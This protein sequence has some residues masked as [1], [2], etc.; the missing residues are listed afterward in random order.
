MSYDQNASEDF[1]M[2]RRRGGSG[3]IEQS[4]GSVQERVAVLGKIINDL[5]GKLAG[6]LGGGGMVKGI[7]PERD[8]PVMSPVLA[9]LRSVEADLEERMDSLR[10]IME[11]IEL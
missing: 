7:D 8:R 9:G 6:V 11:R 1:A 4:L 2:D 3:P 5:E 10:S